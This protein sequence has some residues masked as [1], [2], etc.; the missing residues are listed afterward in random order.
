MTE[1]TGVWLEDLTGPEA[2]AR[3]DADAVVVIPVAT[4]ARAYGAHLPLKTSALIAR[5]LGQKLIGRLPVVVAPV[6]GLGFQPAKASTGLVVELVEKLRAEGVR[7]VA[8]VETDRA[9]GNPFGGLADVLALPVHA[10]RMIADDRDTS[11]MLAL[12]PRSVRMDRLDP[13][14]DLGQNGATAFKGER[15]LAAW[16]DDIAAALVEKWPDLA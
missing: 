3:F 14:T 7:R 2:K 10:A 5:A 15:L 13:A 16:V 9:A 4:T 6:V 12:D 1:R 11:V 8:I